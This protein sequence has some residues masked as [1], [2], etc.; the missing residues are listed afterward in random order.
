MKAITFQD[1]ERVTHE[2][3]SDPTIESQHDA[4][5]KVEL[6]GV[7][8]SDLHVYHG[9][10]QGLD[11]G[12][13]LGHEFV[14]EIQAVGRAVR[15][16]EPGDRI[17]SPFTT[18][19][20]ACFYCRRGL[21]ARC[22]RGQLF[23][24][25]EDGRGLHGA[26]AE[27]VRVP[28]ADSTLV[29][30]PEGL[31]AE[32]ALLAGDVLSTGFFAAKSGEIEPGDF[33]V[34]LGCGP[35]G[36]MAALSS[37]LLG[38]E[39]VL[40]CDRIPERLALAADLKA[41]PL[42]LDG[43]SSLEIVTQATEGRG[44]DVVIEAV[45]SQNAT[46][47]AVDLVRPGGVVS[48]VGVHTEPNFTFSPVLA[49]DKNLTYKIGRCSARYYMDTTLQLLTRERPPVT[50]IISHRLPLSEGSQAYR[51]FADRAEGC[52]KAVLVP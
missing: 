20:G 23:G 36:L 40:A 39:R 24:W 51:L 28:L 41:E 5:V 26:Q 47:L 7:C 18:S 44:A 43:P 48:V 46:R 37:R 9:R 30:V 45:G 50:N 11:A 42:P 35:V 27:Y 33:V 1:V 52:T 34:V 15:R 3:V 2:E 29:E 25:R 10:E 38:A 14:G 32:A 4:I 6:A 13:V 21:T 19:C 17:V 8:G 22:S 31:S 12:T 16:F 49:Y